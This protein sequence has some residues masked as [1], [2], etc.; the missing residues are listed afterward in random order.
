[1]N[2]SMYNLFPTPVE[3]RESWREPTTGEREF[4][5]YI[6]SKERIKKLSAY[7]S[8]N[9]H[10]KDNHILNAPDMINLRE[11]LTSAINTYH[12]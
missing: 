4:F 6:E 12:S 8:G 3:V 9:T 7:P 10:T 11:D 5:T 2:S 1:M